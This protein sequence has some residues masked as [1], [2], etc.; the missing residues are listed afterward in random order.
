MQ[1]HLVAILRA[2][3]RRGRSTSGLKPLN[4]RGR[5]AVSVRAEI[6]AYRESEPEKYLL[7]MNFYQALQEKKILPTLRELRGFAADRGLP[8]IEADARQRAINPFMRSLV[9]L[10]IDSL[11]DTVRGID[12]YSRVQDSLQGWS[13]II[14]D[15][16]GD[17]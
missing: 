5:A 6:D 15:R 7:L 17:A 11:K 10:P 3:A 1:E 13:N 12:S 9:L 2:T 8:A 4:R 14:L 16:G